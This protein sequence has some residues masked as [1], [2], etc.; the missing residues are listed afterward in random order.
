MHNPERPFPGPDVAPSAPIA[1][2]GGGRA[3]TWAIALF[4]GLAAGLIAWGIGEATLVPEAGYQDKKQHI[5]ILPEVA[6]L[7]NCYYSFGALGAAMGL[8]L[9]MAGGLIR[10]SA[11]R[12]VIAGLTGLVL[13]G[14]GG[15][16]VTRLILPVYYEHAKSGE[17]FYSLLV[18]AGIWTELAAV[19]GVAFAVGAAGWRG[20]PRAIL[21]AA[22]AGLVAAL[23]Y[24]FGGGILVPS[25]LTDRPISQT[26]SSRLLARLLVTVLVAA[27]VV[28]CMEPDGGK[29][30]A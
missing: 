10:R 16:A 17:I 1:R 11:S 7:Q 12:A 9:G 30:S 29:K 21:G 5:D 24:E 4:A 22:I 2:V 3:R 25:A 19:A 27:G 26:W 18:H 6:G 8:S 15:L 23:I 20:L 14:A 28:L 13:G